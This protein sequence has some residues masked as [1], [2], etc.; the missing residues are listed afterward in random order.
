MMDERGGRLEKW[1]EP[2]GVDANQGSPSVD[3]GG[4][5]H[6]AEFGRDAWVP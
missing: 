1:R 2:F 6:H 5:D 3:P 4:F